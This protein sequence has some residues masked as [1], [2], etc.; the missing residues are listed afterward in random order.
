[1]IRWLLRKIL[2]DVNMHHNDFAQKLGYSAST[3]Q[4]WL[5]G[6]FLPNSEAC[7]CIA[8]LIGK[9]CNFDDAR[10]LKF[11]QLLL[12]LRDDEFKIRKNL[13]PFVAEPRNR[14]FKEM[15]RNASAHPMYMDGDWEKEWYQPRMGSSSS[16]EIRTRHE[17][18]LAR[19]YAHKGVPVLPEQNGR[20]HLEPDSIRLQ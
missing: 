6:Q 4:K 17:L 2:K 5:D 15:L 12:D 20:Q 14:S 16:Q 1:M 8:I 13:R 11:R 9:E 18:A 3:V 19:A 7:E 10:L